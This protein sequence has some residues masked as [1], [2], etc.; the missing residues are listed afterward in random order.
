MKTNFSSLFVALLGLLFAAPMAIYAQSA[1]E[2]SLP[3]S[4]PPS[5]QSVPS[6][7]EV[8]TAPQET[9]QHQQ[10]LL[11]SATFVGIPIKNAQGEE[12]GTIRELMI[13]PHNGKVIY[14][15]LESSGVFSIG[16]QKS[17]AVPWSALRIGLNQTEVIV[18]FDADQFP[19]SSNVALN[20]R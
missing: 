5:E 7:P 2:P 18:E 3:V 8:T 10:T 14:A 4:S 6:S 11:S 19:T 16:K 20:Q 15:V 12:L 17:F 1:G 9:L 13:D